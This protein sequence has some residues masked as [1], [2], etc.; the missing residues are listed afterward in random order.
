VIA[1]LLLSLIGGAWTVYADVQNV[2]LKLENVKTLNGEIRALKTQ[3]NTL[4]TQVIN[5]PRTLDTQIDETIDR[6]LAD[7]PLCRRR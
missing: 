7:V 2:K 5:L 6:R 3:L 4:T 1:G